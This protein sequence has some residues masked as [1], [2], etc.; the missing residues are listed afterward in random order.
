MSKLP[1]PDPEATDS[2][3]IIDG[4]LC[5]LNRR[6]KVARRHA[7]LGSAIVEFRPLADGRLLVR[8]RPADMLPGFANL[9]CLDADLR[10]VWLAEPPA[11]GALFTEPMSLDAG[12]ATCGTTSGHTLR[13]D[14]AS[15]RQA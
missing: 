6:G 1:L 13:L 14:L 4:A 12:S 3:A 11:D 2:L 8:E 7:P 5:R 15:G 10:Q 9:Y